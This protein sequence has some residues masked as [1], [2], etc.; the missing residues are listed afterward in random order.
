MTGPILTAMEGELVKMLSR[1]INIA[2]EGKH[3][4]DHDLTAGHCRVCTR[5]VEAGALVERLT[6]G[7]R[8]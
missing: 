5:L 6:G 3:Q 7:H 8:P 1:V 4:D 2:M